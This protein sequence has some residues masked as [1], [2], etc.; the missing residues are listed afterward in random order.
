M[1]V[2][3]CVSSA[4]NIVHSIVKYCT[5]IWPVNGGN[6]WA[7]MTAGT[8]NIVRSILY[9]MLYIWPVNGGNGNGLK[10]ENVSQNGCGIEV[11]RLS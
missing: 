8:I 4:I 3:V 1:Q 7:C 11:K 6:A 5:V 2:C 10:I 9:G